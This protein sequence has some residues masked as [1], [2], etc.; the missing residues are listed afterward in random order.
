MSNNS[1]PYLVRGI[2]N[3]SSGDIDKALSDY[4]QAAKLADCSDWQPFF[5]MALVYAERNALLQAS[6]CAKEVL[7]RNPK[8]PLRNNLEK[9]I[10]LA[11][12]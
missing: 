8:F 11:G 1:W 7:A 10:A 12:R 3:E 9:L 5:R 6:D 2:R 4:Q